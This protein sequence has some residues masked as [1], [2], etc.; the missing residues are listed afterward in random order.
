MKSRLTKNSKLTLY[1]QK[2]KIMVDSGRH[3]FFKHERIRCMFHDKNGEEQWC[4]LDQLPSMLTDRNIY[5]R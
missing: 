2:S 1:I 4:Y 5:L 3:Y